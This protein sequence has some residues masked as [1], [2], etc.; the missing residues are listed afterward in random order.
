MPKDPLMK[1]LA[2]LILSTSLS[3]KSRSYLLARCA[4]EAL[5]SDGHEPTTIDLRDLGLPLCDG[6]TAYGHESV[7]PLAEAIEGADG[8]II[9][10]PVYNYDVNAALKTAVELTGK[11]WTGQAVGF[12]AAAGGQGSYMALC[13]VMNSLMLDFRAVCVPRFVYAT[14]DAFDAGPGGEELTDEPIRARVAEVATRTA[15]LSRAWREIVA[16][17]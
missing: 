4:G 15:L 17:D 11:A 16:A 10:T 6:E 8:V 1:P 14:G 3:S 13:G 9:A 5:E 7:R 2:P 12:M